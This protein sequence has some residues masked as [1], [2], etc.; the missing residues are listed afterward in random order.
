VQPDARLTALELNVASLQ[1]EL[2]LDRLADDT[3][4][5]R[6]QGVV[7]A[8]AVARDDQ[9]IAQALLL[10]ATRD[11]SSSVRSAA[12]DALGPQ[13]HSESMGNQLMD[14]LASAE[15]PLVQLALVD[16]VLR[17]GNTNQLAQLSQLAADNRLHP[18]L[19]RHVHNSLGGTST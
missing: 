2:I 19:V 3:V 18:D 13:L 16:L 5:T 11:R 8:S 4:S 12:I 7:E 15:S 14:L 6:L 1:R 9:V 10:R 17:N